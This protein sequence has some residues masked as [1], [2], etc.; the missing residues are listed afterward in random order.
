MVK[1]PLFFKDEGAM[2]DVFEV[3]KQI[4]EQTRLS[5][6]DRVRVSTVT[7]ERMKQLTGKFVEYDTINGQNNEYRIKVHQLRVKLLKGEITPDEAKVALAGLAQE[8][9]ALQ[10]KYAGLVEQLDTQM[11]NIDAEVASLDERATNLTRQRDQYHSALHMEVKWLAEGELKELAE[12]R[13]TLKKRRVSL[14]EEKGLIFNRKEELA[15]SF[16]LVEDVLGQKRTRYISAE[17]ARASELDFLARFDMKMNAFPVKI[18]SPFEAMTYTVN[19]WRSHNHYD[20]G[21]VPQAA[22]AAPGT[23]LP[24]NAGSVYAIQEKKGWGINWDKPMSPVSFSDD[25]WGSHS[26]AYISTGFASY[27]IERGT[28]KKKVVA[29]AFSYCNLKDYADL[30]FDTRP[31]TL[32][33][34]MGILQPI[35][36]AAEAGDYYHVIGI[37]SPTGWDEGVIAW[38]TG[39]AYASRN[40]AVCLIDSV[41]GEV[42]YNKSDNRILS[43]ADYYRH[44]FDKERVDKIKTVIRAD[45]ESVEYLE[46]EK[47]FEKTSEDPVHHPAGIL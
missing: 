11:K 26:G 5:R 41:L 44:E 16:S 40:V 31:V 6:E 7:D 37:A 2:G 9:D 12:L 21:Q 24:V 3:A 38:V 43:Y 30:G 14:V 18:F 20:A 35:I 39:T 29:E 19:G 8:R 45:F 22:G 36:G 1:E 33:T 13:E 47:I 46:F 27:P 32:P 42:Y 23:A 28:G 4:I 15:E 10:A 34:L 17:T 25:S